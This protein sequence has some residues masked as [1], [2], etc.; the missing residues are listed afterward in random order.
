MNTPTHILIGAGAFARPGRPTVVAAAL[1]GG[2][3]PD[4]SLFA[5]VGWE[6]LIEG[7]SMR[8][9]FDHTYYDPI[10]Q[11]VFAIDNSA[12]LYALLIGVALL[13]RAPALAAFAGA[14]ILHVLVDL[15]LHAGDGRPH[16]WP[17]SAWV[18]HSPV[19]YWDRAHYGGAVAAA[20]SALVVALAALL[21]RRFTDWRARAIL[22]L[23]AALQVA[24][25][26]LLALSLVA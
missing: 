11:T 5:M 12:P 24:I 17:F 25:G 22:A 6:R 10:W 9:I 13:A 3:A 19:S 4:L 14:A 21:W 20:E 15:P 7:R 1:L 23:V 2:A 16:F 26:S 8:E 18:F